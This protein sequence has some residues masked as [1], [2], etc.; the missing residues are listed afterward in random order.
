[1]AQTK[2]IK[3]ED[4]ILVQGLSDF[5]RELRRIAQDGGPDGRELLK[6][7]NHKVASLVV[8]SARTKA[9]GVGALQAKAASTLVAGRAQAKATVT[10]G[11]ARV[12][13]FFGAEFG[14]KANILRNRRTRPTLGYNQ[15]EIWK[16]PGNGNTGYFLF[17]TLKDESRTIIELY[18]EELE[19]ITKYAFPN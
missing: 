6:E 10:G 2:N 17:P 14:A 5:R 1:M 13:F 16:K 7:A 4:R 3:A 18:G 8:T 15:F 19:K 11:N 9:A 12:P